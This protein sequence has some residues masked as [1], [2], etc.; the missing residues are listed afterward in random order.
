MFI[1]YGDSRVGLIRKANEDSISDCSG[2]FFILADGMGGYVGGQVASSL[3]VQSGIDFLKDIP[4]RNIS[5]DLLR[6]SVLHANHIV[7]EQKTKN[8]E[9]S[10]MGTTMITAE[11]Y[12]DKLSWAHVGDS[13]LYI[14]NHGILK[15]LTKDHSFVMELLA[16]G[17]ITENEMREHPRRNE[18]TRA[19]GIKE[20]L[21]VDTGTVE[22]K[23]NT[24]ILLCTDGLTGMVDDIHISQILSEYKNF[25]KDDLVNC[26]E[27]LFKA[28]YDNGATDNVSLI[29]IDYWERKGGE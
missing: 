1:A 26:G 27:N 29:L 8:R 15:Q 5:E 12:E 19:V 22:L 11:I 16:K 4:L 23:N 28:A 21:N 13:R 3:A 14:Y 18:I 20:A 25:T 2:P 10:G 9:L 6:K 24:L 17:K 7:I